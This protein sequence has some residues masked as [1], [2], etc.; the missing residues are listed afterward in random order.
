MGS[1]PDLKTAGAGGLPEKEEMYRL[2]AAANEAWLFHGTT[3]AGANGITYGDFKTSLAGSH[4]GTMYGRGVYLAESP[5]KSD[6]YTVPSGNEEGYAEP[7]RLLLLC[8]ATLGRISYNDDYHPDARACA[9]SCREG[10]Y[11]SVLGD[12]EKVVKTYREFILFDHNQVYPEYV[13]FYRRV[14]DADAGKK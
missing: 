14:Y 12:R 1:V 10:P 7:T 4:A 6:E 13:L 8:R 2:D 5:S 11:H 9:K 3:V